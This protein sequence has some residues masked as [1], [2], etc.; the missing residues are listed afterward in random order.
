MPK[1]G[2]LSQDNL[3][4]INYND[5]MFANHL[6]N[7]P[8]NIESEVIFGAPGCG[9]T[10]KLLNILQDELH[11]TE[12]SKIAFCS[13]TRAGTREGKQRSKKQ[14]KFK[15]DDMKYFRTLH[16]LAYNIGSFETIDLINFK[17]SIKFYKEAGL[18]TR[19][20][21]YEE[22]ATYEDIY[23]FMFSLEKN[24]IE[25]FYNFCSGNR[26]MYSEN[27]YENIKQSYCEFKQQNQIFDYTDLLF[28]VWANQFKCPVEVAIID[29]VQDMTSLQWLFCF[30]AF[31]DAKRIYVA[32]DDD[33]AI[34]EWNG[35]DVK[36]FHNVRGKRTILNKSYRLKENILH[37]AKTAS[38]FIENR[39]D[40][41]FEPID[42]GGEINYYYQVK[43]VP[44]QDEGTYYI[45]CRNRYFLQKM[46]LLLMRMTI[47]FK[48]KVKEGFNLSISNKKLKAIYLFKKIQSKVILSD[49]EV[50]S[51][52]ATFDE[53]EFDKNWWEQQ[54]M[55]NMSREEIMYYDDLTDKEVTLTEKNCNKYIISTIH[56]VKGGE[57]DNVIL[58]LDHTSAVEQ[59]KI[60]NLDSELRCIYVALT[61]TKNK[62]HIVHGD[63]RNN[64]ND[65]FSAF[66]TDLQQRHL[67]YIIDK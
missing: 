5:P 11:R 4:S 9:K 54:E 10:T 28:Y 7:I 47:P 3:Y 30:S 42:F 19:K 1:K 24:N 53:P 48:Y 62:L 22:F 6:T 50:A 64:Y 39:V 17:Q 21:M 59:T 41:Q 14:F 16:S 66:V 43:D 38:S 34:F 58:F 44:L 13:F 26:E 25:A 8:V 56:G 23:L 29:E 51:F 31:S 49:K 45:L 27:E 57:A 35:A 67:D 55:I 12:I 60:K 65:L 15:D 37:L 36:A 2:K 61:R 46:N 40:K 32:G 63:S 52:R 33:Q 18:A 20:G